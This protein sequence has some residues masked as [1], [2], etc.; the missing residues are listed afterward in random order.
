MLL[1]GNLLGG[2]HLG[3]NLL[4]DNPLVED[5]PA[6]VGNP[7]VQ[8]L[9]LIGNHL[10]EDMVLVVEDMVLVVEGMAL[11]VGGMFQQGDKLQLMEDTQDHLVDTV[12]GLMACLT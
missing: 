3:G 12:E 7:L 10:L 9:L 1:G 5:N 8:V 6:V 4:V 2:N 11:A